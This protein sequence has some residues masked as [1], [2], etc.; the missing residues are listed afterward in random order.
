MRGKNP[1]CFAHKKPVKEGESR[2]ACKRSMRG[3]QTFDK[4]NQDAAAAAAQTQ[5]APCKEHQTSER[6]TGENIDINTS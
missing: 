2:A 1:F 6:V 5:T 4:F 3:D